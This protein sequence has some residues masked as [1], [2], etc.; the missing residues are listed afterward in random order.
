MRELGFLQLN[1][2]EGLEGTSMPSLAY[3]TGSCRDKRDK[4]SFQ[5]CMVIGNRQKLQHRK[6][7]ITNTEKIL[8]GEQPNTG[9]GAQRDC[10]IPITRNCAFEQEVAWDDPWD[11]PS[12]W[13]T[14]LY[15]YLYWLGPEG[16]WIVLQLLSFRIL[17]STYQKVLNTS[18]FKFYFSNT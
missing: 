7:W 11:S 5:K 9:P 16:D 1:R 10:G 15:K 13:V 12:T 18:N 3:L 6:F 8:P 17:T 14:H 4:K 2:K